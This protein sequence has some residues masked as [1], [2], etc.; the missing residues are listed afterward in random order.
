M[1]IS[2]IV[3]TEIRF[4]RESNLV[5]AIRTQIELLVK[6]LETRK[7]PMETAYHYGKLRCDLERRGKPMGTND[8]RIAAHALAEN[9][10][11]VS[12]HTREFERVT[13]LHIENWLGSA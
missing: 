11:L 7:L 3:L 4:E 5:T 2:V 12:R 9:A 6:S 13:G 10:V 1:F 8:Y